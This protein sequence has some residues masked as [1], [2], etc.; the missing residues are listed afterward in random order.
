MEVHIVISNLNSFQL[1]G[2]HYRGV[3][4]MVARKIHALEVTG[5][6]PVSAINVK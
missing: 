6:S 3:E 4:Q 5:S 1:E 2:I